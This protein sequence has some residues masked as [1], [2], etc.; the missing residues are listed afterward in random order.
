MALAAPDP[1]YEPLA[2][3]AGHCWKG[4][5]PGGRQTDEHCFSWIY[6]GKFLRD[7]HT[8]RAEGKA[9]A[10]GESIYWWNP[11]AKQ[12]EYLYIESGG[13][14]SRGAVA[15][16]EESLV[17]PETR[18]VEDGKVMM[19]RSRWQRSGAKAYEV[20]TEFQSKAGWAPGFKVHMEQQAQMEHGAESTP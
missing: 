2:Y 18:F 10:M 9:D 8:V 14:F 16:D 20:V 15:I 13:C 11:A 5:F 6:G 19:Y 7:R 4:A 12:L 17:F 1:A 3:L